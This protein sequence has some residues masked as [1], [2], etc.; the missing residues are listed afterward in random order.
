MKNK[1]KPIIFIGILLIM[2]GIAL[3][4]YFYPTTSTT[5]TP[6]QGPILNWI[7]KGPVND[8]VNATNKKWDAELKSATNIFSCP[9][10][11]DTSKL[12]LTIKDVMTVNVDD[13]YNFDILLIWESNFN[14]CPEKIPGIKLK[15]LDDTQ[16][17]G[18]SY[19]IPF[20]QEAV[21]TETIINRGDKKRYYQT[22]MNSSAEGYYSFNPNNKILLSQLSGI[23]NDALSLIID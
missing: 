4:I 13:S 22:K 1:I 5:P 12:V 8:A 11:V 17:Q 16:G 14:I 19:K 3:T 6:G 2:V 15:I 9:S 10:S 21:T 20:Q 23:G 18:F 7:C